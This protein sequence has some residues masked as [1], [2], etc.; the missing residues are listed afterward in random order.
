[1]GAENFIAN[2]HPAYIDTLYKEFQN[3]TES[4]EE[5]KPKAPLQ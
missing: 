3:N 4:V 2:A 1:M 5:E